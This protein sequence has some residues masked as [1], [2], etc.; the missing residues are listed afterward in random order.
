MGPSLNSEETVREYLLGRV[1][2]E[3]TLEGL[4]EL[5][6]NDE[7]F[8]SQVALA[9]DA[10][11]NDYVLNALSEADAESFRAT[12]ADNPERRFKVDLT[13]ALR[14]KARARSAVTAD[15]K[16]SFFA[17]LA[18][19]FKQPMYAGAFAVLLIAAVA[20]V[21]YFNSSSRTDELA[22]LRSIYRQARP[23]ETRITE[24][25]YAPLPQLRG[26]P[27]PAETNR[28]R[29][30]ENNLIE[31]TEKTA[32]AQTFHAL[33][34]F[35]LTQRKY[36]EAIKEFE[37][38]I[39]FDDKNAKVHNDLGVAHFELAKAGPKEKKFEDMA[40]AL[41]EFTKASN[42]DSNSLEALFN[43]SLALQELEMP[44]EAKESWARYLEKDSSSPWADEA[45]RHLARIESERTLFKSPEQ[46]LS[47]FLTAYRAHDEGRAQN[48]HNE[49][50]GLLRGATVPLQLSQ[51]YLLARQ[52]GNETEGKESIKALKFI[53]AFEQAQNGDS[54][55]FELADFYANVPP[56]MTAPLLQAHAHFSSGQAAIANFKYAGA[57]AEFERSR[58]L[59]ASRG[60]N[61]DAAVAELWA[62]QFLRDVARV[63]EGRQRLVAVIEKAESRHYKVLLPP[64]YYW[65]GLSAFSQSGL[66]ETNQNLKT[67]LRL[68]ESGHNAFAIQHANDALTANYAQLGE[69]ETA[70]SYAGKMINNQGR[71]Y[72]SE[73]QYWRDKGTLAD[74]SIKLKFFSTALSLSKER[75][76]IV[77]EPPGDSSRLNNS[78]RQL[79]QAAQAGGDFEAALKYANESLQIARQRDDS[80]QN[81]LVAAEIHGLLGELK[82]QTEDCEAALTQYDQAL[83]LYR[84]L[85]EVTSHLYRLHKGKLFCFEKLGRQADFD[86]ELAAVLKLSEAYR[87]TIR[88]DASRQTFFANEQVVFDAATANALK[89]GDARKAF[90]FGEASR[91]RSLLD[92]VESAKPIAEVERSFGAVTKPLSLAEIQ[93]R[94]PDQV[95]LLQYA[96]LPDR[97]A[98]WII[99][100][101]RFDLVEKQI[102]SAELETKIDRY[103]AAILEKAPAAEIKQAG[104]ELYELLIPTG[105]TADK[106]I[107]LV[108]D[109]SLHQ[110]AFATLVSR[111]GKYLL[112]DY[113]LFYAPSASVLVMATENARSK[114]QS[115]NESLLSIGNPEF[116]REENVNLADLR[117]AE[118]EARTIAGGYH[119]SVELL[120]SAATREAFLKHFESAT[121]IHFAGHFVANR[122]SPANSKLLFAGGELRSSELSTYKLPQSKLVVLSACETGF[123]SYNKSEG[124]IG[125]A[126]TLLAM[127][128]PL[129]V[130]SQWQVDSEP[131]KDLMIAFHRNRNHGGM[132]SALSLRRAQLE[133]LS[134]EETQAPFYWAAFSLY[135]GYANY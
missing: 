65:V 41:E 22:E 43:K 3:T 96:V 57:I 21:I 6:F 117:S 82:S 15:E 61:C 12:L 9:E 73:T 126:R 86:T 111:D 16:P 114:E 11:I 76:S 127:G 128:A 50:K 133:I 54:F 42:L 85:P 121:I 103:Q 118:N 93:A 38:A 98:L 101:T 81:S 104:Q 29:R 8:C 67:A 87:A 32:N 13:R 97:L 49:T 108:P 99:S 74:L 46:V 125:I 100:K 4:E 14:E 48:I 123:E 79:A 84:R 63:D 80:N 30:I 1:S 106:Q 113:P 2:D 28:L 55:F 34:I 105:L 91:A 102:T 20:L 88:E 62:A 75:V 129:V 83:N 10:L 52:N 7:E 122:Q 35:N 58:D 37:R 90:A 115:A 89:T 71:Y 5:L 78:L 109:K 60:D 24:F 47:D 72:Q 66:S 31:A 110:L 25:D 131:T 44:H 36:R 120:G 116:D 77:R 51:R 68:A 119:K 56:E 94:L 107:C 132:P 134:K 135:G 26:A 18:S 70:L 45:R 92:F 27:D 95:Q 69:L 112:Q 53:G 19:L 124:A 59:F 33:G 23:T 39:K 64:T 40:L 130:A 17:S